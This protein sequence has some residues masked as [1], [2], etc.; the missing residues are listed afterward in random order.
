MVDVK[1][2]N[3]KHYENYSLA[4]KSV[5]RF[6]MGILD[7]MPKKFGSRLLNA[8]KE[9]GNVKRHATSHLAIEVMYT[10]TRKPIRF[11][12]YLVRNILTN[13]W[14]NFTNP[15]ALRNRLKLVQKVIVNKIMNIDSNDDRIN[16]L[17]LGSG[18]ARAIIKVL[19]DHNLSGYNIDVK[20]IDKSE[21]ALAY[22]K[23][24]SEEYGVKNN[25]EW[26]QDDVRN[27]MEHA[28]YWKPNIVEMVGLL[29][30]FDDK[31]AIE[32]ISNIHKSL[33]RGSYLVTCNIDTNYERNFI[34]RVV[35]WSMVYRNS[36]QLINLLNASGFKNQNI[37]VIYEPLSIHGIIIGKK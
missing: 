12:K 18:S 10:Y 9:A 23:K 21:H 32:L 28:H 37:E 8:S 22:S 19:T 7:L 33:P 34:T 2:D 1:K 29:D 16:I 25:I 3:K 36:K 15:K 30:Y 11:G 13:V 24:L 26:I 35:K 31:K 20:L 4:H 14:M 6:L 27:F 5:N 17:S